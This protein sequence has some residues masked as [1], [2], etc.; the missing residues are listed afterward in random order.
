MNDSTVVL[1]LTFLGEYPR[2]IHRV[3][4]REKATE[5]VVWDVIASGGTAE[6]WKIELN[7]GENPADGVRPYRGRFNASHAETGKSFELRRSVAYS[8]RIWFRPEGRG[9][10]R[11]FEVGQQPEG[12]D[13][14]GAV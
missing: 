9:C 1:D 10:S 11:D 8:V 12:G 13:L 2:A 7:V 6:L 14:N 5:R 3:Q 4:L